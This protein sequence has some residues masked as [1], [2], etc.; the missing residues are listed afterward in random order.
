VIED[1]FS[2]SVDFIFSLV[3]LIMAL[4]VH[5]LTHV[6]V[7]TSDM[8]VVLANF[9]NVLIILTERGSQLGLTVLQCMLMKVAVSKKMGCKTSTT[10]ADLPTEGSHKDQE[11]K[12][13]VAD[14]RKIFC[15]HEL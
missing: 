14:E 6:L 2:T 11:T 3:L 12:T 5:V 7:L 15:G 1:D 4:R 9:T 8:K 10:I 13:F